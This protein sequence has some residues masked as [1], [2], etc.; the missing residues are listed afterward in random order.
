MMDSL[1]KISPKKLK[2]F[3]LTLIIITC[4]II[5]TVFIGYRR[6]LNRPDVLISSF[7]KDANLSLE[8]VRQTATKNGIKEWSLGASSAHYNDKNK[9]A[10]L[11]DVSVTFFLKNGQQVNVTAD[12]GILKTDSSDIE[13]SGNVVVKN[14]K[15]KLNTQNIFYDHHRRLIFSKTPVK[16]WSED[17]D[18]KA[19]SITF[20]LNTNRAAL[21]GNVKGTFFENFQ[22]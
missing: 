9:Q 4:V 3:L 11:T 10:F 19:D 2:F 7:N 15:Y 20:D 13:A 12:K 22:L 1:K 14:G 8:R 5:I 6:I 16:I 21:K 18:L 17:F